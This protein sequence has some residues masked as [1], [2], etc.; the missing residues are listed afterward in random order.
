MAFLRKCNSPLLHTHP[1]GPSRA[2]PLGG[3]PP[4]R[5]MCSISLPLAQG[6]QISTTERAVVA[7]LMGFSRCSSVFPCLP[8]PRGFSALQALQSAPH[9]ASLNFGAATGP[10]LCRVGACSGE[11]TD[12]WRCKG[13][14]PKTTGL[15]ARQIFSL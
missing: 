15:G 3:A 9:H 14:F 10:G 1:Q 4:R 8:S 6:C 13:C 5:A 2:K 11:A 7:S 12:G